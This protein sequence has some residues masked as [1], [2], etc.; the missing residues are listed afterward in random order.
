[1]NLGD[2]KL[3]FKS[4]RATNEVTA[5]LSIKTSFKPAVFIPLTFIESSCSSVVCVRISFPY[6]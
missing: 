4:K 2:K 1:M 3:N 6:V 5:L